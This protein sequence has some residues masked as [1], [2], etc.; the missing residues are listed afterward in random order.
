M[1]VSNV[2]GHVCVSVFLSVQAITFDPLGRYPSW[3]GTTPPQA[4]TPPQR[5]SMN[6][7]YAS[8]W[9]AFLLVLQLEYYQNVQYRKG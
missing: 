1:R 4:G 8:Y 7:R 9:N 3:A 6:G 5:W 2:F